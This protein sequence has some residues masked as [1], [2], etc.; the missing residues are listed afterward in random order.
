MVL[1]KPK[2]PKSPQD[3]QFLLGHPYKRKSPGKSYPVD[4]HNLI[5]RQWGCFHLPHLL[6]CNPHHKSTK[7][8]G[9]N[10][11][12]L[13]HTHYSVEDLENRIHLDRIIHRFSSTLILLPHVD[14]KHMPEC[15]SVY[16]QTQKCNKKKISYSTRKAGSLAPERNA[17]QLLQIRDNICCTMTNNTSNS[18]HLIQNQVSPSRL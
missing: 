14:L 15:L 7:Y 2:T 11:V 8:K 12:Y 6:E 10:D 5:S 3:R 1:K 4:A 9:G 16:S 17:Q 13:I 18:L